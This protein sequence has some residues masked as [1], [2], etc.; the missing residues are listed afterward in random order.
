MLDGR[1]IYFFDDTETLRR[2]WSSINFEPVGELCVSFVMD[3]G[4]AADSCQVD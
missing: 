4:T 3:L 1:N 2:E